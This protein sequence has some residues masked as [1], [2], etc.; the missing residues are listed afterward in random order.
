MRTIICLLSVVVL[1]LGA[2]GQQA[3]RVTPRTLAGWTIV[4]ADPQT[5]SMQQDLVLPAGAQLARSFR[6]A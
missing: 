3:L 5:L 6:T 1:S 4:G 2:R